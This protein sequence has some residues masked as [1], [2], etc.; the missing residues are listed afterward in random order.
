MTQWRVARE[1]SVPGQI[2]VIEMMVD[3]DEQTIKWLFEGTQFAFSTLTNYL[4]Y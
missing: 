1:P 4:K 2:G 3:V